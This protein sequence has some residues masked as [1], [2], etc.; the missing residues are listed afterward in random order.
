MEQWITANPQSK[1]GVHKYSL[2]QF[3]LSE[4]AI[5]ERII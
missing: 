4:A 1:Y 5:R 3:G 2:E